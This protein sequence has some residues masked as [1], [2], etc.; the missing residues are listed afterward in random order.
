VK[1]LNKLK[2]MKMS[3]LMQSLPFAGNGVLATLRVLAGIGVSVSGAGVL[4]YEALGV[5]SRS[6]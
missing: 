3:R 4:M 5:V 6:L 1:S 2:E